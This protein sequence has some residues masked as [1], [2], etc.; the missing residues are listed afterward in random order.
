MGHSSTARGNN[1]AERQVHS[2]AAGSRHPAQAVLPVLLGSASHD[3]QAARRQGQVE[4][5]QIAP[6]SV[7]EI[8]RTGCTETE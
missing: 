4:G 5:R 2:G 7:P 1:P 3:Q 6:G 8:E